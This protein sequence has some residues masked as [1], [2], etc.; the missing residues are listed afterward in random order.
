M[1]LKLFVFLCLAAFAMAEILSDEEEWTNFKSKHNKS[2]GT[3]DEEARRYGI[4]KDNLS[5]IREHQKK[6]EAGE[7]SYSQGVNAFTDLTTEEFK[8]THTGGLSHH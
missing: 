2:Y 6:F 4:F 8:K 1:Q 3:P 7:V 5:N